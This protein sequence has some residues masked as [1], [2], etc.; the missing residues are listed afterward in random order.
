VS[1]RVCLPPLGDRH[2]RSLTAV[3]VREPHRG[4]LT[5]DQNAR[6]PIEVRFGV[7]TANRVA[8]RIWCLAGFLR[9][10]DVV[11]GNIREQGVI[12]RVRQQHRAAL[13]C[14][15][16][17]IGTSLRG[18]RAQPACGRLKLPFEVESDIHQ[19]A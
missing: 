18:E 8:R 17:S 11:S 4:W 3:A 14:V 9:D 10:A 12:W 1:S 6:L 16:V 19:D 13:Y 2:I 7:A 15:R 5:L